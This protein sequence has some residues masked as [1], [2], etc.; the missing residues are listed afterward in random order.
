MGLFARIKFIRIFYQVLICLLSKKDDQTN[1][2]VDCNRLLTTAS[3]MLFIMSNTV[4]LGIKPSGQCFQINSSK[5]SRNYSLPFTAEN[6]HIMGFEPLINQR[7][8]P[9]TFPRYTKIK[10]R[11]ESL[12]YFDDVINRLK[13]L[14]KIQS[15]TALHQAL[16]SCANW[17]QKSRINGGF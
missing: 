10:P 9:P 7:L 14:N 17:R 5:I 4:D 6:M 13:I 15:I 3:D 11:N 2:M 8:L 12:T 16:V 1:L